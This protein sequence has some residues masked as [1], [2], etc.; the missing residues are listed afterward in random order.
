MTGSKA[1]YSPS[2]CIWILGL[3]TIPEEQQE[4]DRLCRLPLETVVNFLVILQGQA[5]K[6]SPLSIFSNEIIGHI[7]SF[8][9]T[10]DNP[11]KIAKLHDKAFDKLR[12]IYT[13][14]TQTSSEFFTPA[15][16]LP[17]D[18]TPEKKVQEDEN[19]SMELKTKPG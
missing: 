17:E 11:A 1:N 10:V 15:P 7:F 4:I 5:Q 9:A 19:L 14:R 2:H 12:K 13:S 16:A 3:K 8:V 18:R 6:D